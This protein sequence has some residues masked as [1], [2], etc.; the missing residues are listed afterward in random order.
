M[1]NEY[2]CH[3]VYGNFGYYIEWYREKDS[4]SSEVQHWY[5]TYQQCTTRM[6]YPPDP[7]AWVEIDHT[8]SYYRDAAT[9]S[10]MYD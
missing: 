2:E 10:G 6:Q 4:G 5:G 9:A 8:S 7:D 3:I 1:D